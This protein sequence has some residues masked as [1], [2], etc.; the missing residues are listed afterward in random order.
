MQIKSFSDLDFTRI[1]VLRELG[2]IGMGNA[3]SSLAQMLSN[4]VEMS[5]P[6]A[7]LVDKGAAADYL[8]KLQT[9]SLG[10][11]L[12]L[13]GDING[14]IIHILRKSFAERVINFFF[15]TSIDQIEDIDEM[16]MSVISEVG[17]I[18]SASYVNAIAAMTGLFIDI[19]TPIQCPDLAE[20]VLNPSSANNSADFS[21]KV[22]LID[23]SFFIDREEIKS[24]LIF[25]PE[26]DSLN[27]IFEKLGLQ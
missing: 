3:A 27:L 16:S 8:H 10:I 14:S 21:D 1:D 6:K 12:N 20:A 9:T 18:T 13:Q 15:P 11:I 26:V 24:N 22:L 7:D 2:N 5:V 17:N 25:L 4:K 23:N 19:S